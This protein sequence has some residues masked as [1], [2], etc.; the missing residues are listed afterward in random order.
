M[1]G[2]DNLEPVE[3]REAGAAWL[4]VFAWSGAAIPEVPDDTPWHD[5]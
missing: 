1:N 4:V 5:Q 2:R 3:A